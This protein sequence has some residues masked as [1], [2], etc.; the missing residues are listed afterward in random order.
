MPL[1]I[2]IQS[3]Q[4]RTCACRGQIY[5][6]RGL[7]LYGK[8]CETGVDSLQENAAAFFIELSAEDKKFLEDAFGKDKVQLPYS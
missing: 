4:R 2:K 6:R 7:V 3:A 8:D 1:G 5:G